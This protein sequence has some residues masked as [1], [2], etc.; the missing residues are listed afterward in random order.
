[1]RRAAKP[2]PVL[3]VTV[4]RSNAPDWKERYFRALSAVI[5]ELRTIG[6]PPPE[7]EADEEAEPR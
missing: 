2:E 1:M 7:P 4:H 6:E 3:R 5:P